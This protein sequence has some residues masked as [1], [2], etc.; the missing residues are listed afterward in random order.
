M[1]PPTRSSLGRWPTESAVGQLH[2]ASRTA[3]ALFIG[4][5]MA[6]PAWP[7]PPEGG[8]DPSEGPDLFAAHQEQNR[9]KNDLGG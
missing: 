1:K 6:A 4:T 3:V 8:V 7:C 5:L 2:R 9:H